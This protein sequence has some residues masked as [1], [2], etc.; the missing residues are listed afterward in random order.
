MRRGNA[1]K[2]RKLL[3]LLVLLVA[4][5]KSGPPAPPPAAGPLIN[6]MTDF[7]DRCDACRADRDCLHALRDEFDQVKGPLLA[8]GARIVGDDK[9]TYDQQLAR[10]RACGDGGGLTFWVDP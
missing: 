6:Q 5:S 1:A 4:C 2:R 3:G 8:D 10:L 9:A 7:A